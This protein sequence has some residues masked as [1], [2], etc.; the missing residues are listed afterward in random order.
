MLRVARK[1]LVACSGRPRGVAATVP[2]AGLMSDE[3]STISVQHLS[4]LGSLV[5]PV[6]DLNGVVKRCC[7]EQCLKSVDRLGKG[8]TFPGDRLK[9]PS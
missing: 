3:G 2:E 1:R 5:D 4:R 9:A 6:E 8:R 7:D